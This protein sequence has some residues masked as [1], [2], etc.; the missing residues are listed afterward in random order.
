[1]TICASDV[2]RLEASQVHEYMLKCLQELEHEARVTSQPIPCEKLTA[3]CIAPSDLLSI[4]DHRYYDL[5]NWDSWEHLDACD[6][7]KLDPEGLSL[8]AFDYTSPTAHYVFHL[9]LRVAETFVPAEQ[10]ARLKMR[11][12][13]SRESGEYYG[14]SI[15]AAES[16]EQPIAEILRDLGADIMAICP[17]QLRDKEHSLLTRYTEWY[18]EVDEDTE[19]EDEL[20]TAYW[21]SLIRSSLA[22]TWR[23]P[24]ACPYCATPV[25]SMPEFARVEHWQNEHSGLDLT[26]SQ[27][28]WLMNCTCLKKAFCQRY[29]P[30]YRAPHE[31]GWGTRYWKV[32]TLKAWM[33]ERSHPQT[34]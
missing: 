17:R 25:A 7:R 24:D 29:P 28:S 6:L 5:G 34:V 10:I 19:Q 33:Q 3:L 26:I 22:T 4:Q 9:P 21:H 12:W 11:P 23:E 18:D 14:R 2:E 1:M 20:E 15:T 16:L 30:D 13:T 27:A 31:H 32:A 8:L